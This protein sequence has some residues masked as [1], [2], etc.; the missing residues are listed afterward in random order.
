MTPFHLEKRLDACRE[1]GATPRAIEVARSI[2]AG[3]QIVPTSGAGVQIEVHTC[4][5]DM[6]LEVLPCGNL[7]FAFEP[8]REDQP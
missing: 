7:A 5:F 1:A 6:E 8:A 2:V 4:G 3:I